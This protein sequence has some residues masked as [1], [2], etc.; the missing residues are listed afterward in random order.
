MNTTS[1]NHQAVILVLLTF[2][3]ISFITNIMGPIFPALVSDFSI[4]LMVA[5]FFPFAFFVAYGVMSIPA[6][7]ITER[8]GEKP[9]LISAFLLATAGASLFFLKP[10]LSSAF[11]SL[12]LIGAA[13]AMLQVVINPLLRVA[14][15]EENFAFYSVLAQLVFGAAAT[16]SPIVY[17]YLLKELATEQTS[18][19]K[20][21]FSMVPDNLPWLAM[22]GLFA[23]LTL[24]MLLY[25]SVLRLPTVKL[26]DNERIGTLVLHWQLLK[27]R[28]VQLFFLAIIAYVATE[29]GIAN[30]ASLFLQRYHNL[31]PAVE[32]AAIV[33]QFW[34][35]M[36]IGCLVGLGLLKLIDSRTLLKLFSFMAMIAY[37]A[38]LFGST[39]I[40]LIAFPATGFFL[41]IMWSV[42]FSLALNSTQKNHGSFA[43][44][45]CSGIIGGALVSPIIG[46]IADITGELRLG[47]LIVLLTLFYIF[48]IG[49]WAKPLVVNKIWSANK[50]FNAAEH[51]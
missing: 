25:V 43:G 40:T 34:L 6:G 20:N 16:L 27:S 22:Y 8:W 51:S 1:R 32:G 30:S 50:K 44:I 36:T 41:S 13:M 42:I 48:S 19:I 18:F 47:M 9:V 17:T 21:V 39:S 12:F 5:G 11:I 46:F 29:Q 35:L 3:V 31:N 24:T 4:S 37:G 23:I 45:L 7:M 26:S 14:G 49:F 15:G 10:E 28:Q 2:F 38:A 33:S